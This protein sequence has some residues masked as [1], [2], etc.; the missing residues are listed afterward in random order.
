MSCL[1]QEG[2]KFDKFLRNK[3]VKVARTKQANETE[4]G[5]KENEEGI[6]FLEWWENTGSF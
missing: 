3:K 1:I 2:S 4:V 5:V 6:F